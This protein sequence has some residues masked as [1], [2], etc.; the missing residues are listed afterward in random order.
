MGSW[1][2]MFFSQENPGSLGENR[3]DGG[4]THQISAAGSLW[5]LGNSRELQAPQTSLTC[6]LCCRP[7]WISPQERCFFFF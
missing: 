7:D 1:D 2:P 4:Q 3:C 5:L 6:T